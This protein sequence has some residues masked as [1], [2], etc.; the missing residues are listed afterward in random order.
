MNK[1]I[2]IALLLISAA[3]LIPIAGARPATLPGGGN[4]NPPGGQCS[5]LPVGM[6]LNI[7]YQAPWYCAI[8]AQIT[9][10]WESD[11]PLAEIALLIAFSIASV[12]F[13]VGAGIKSDRIRNFGIGELYEATASAII[14]L[15]FLFVSAVAFGL[16]PSIVVG[17]INPYATS[18]GLINKTINSAEAIYT[19]LFSIYVTDAQYTSITITLLI[20][21]APLKSIAS[22]ILTSI[23]QLYSAPLSIFVLEPASAIGGLI[24]D[25]ITAL[26]A[27]YYLL[28]F[29]ASV[30]IPAFLVPGTIFRAIFPTRAFGGMLIAL[31]MGFFIVMPSLFA[32]A[33]YFT[34]PNLLSSMQLT[35]SQL[36]RFGSGAGA[37]TNGLTA[38]SPLPTLLQNVNSEMSSFW[39]LILFYPSLIMAVTYAFVTQVATFIGGATYTGSRLR[40]FI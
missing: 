7:T 4:S 17:T 30:S 1:S 39:L 32:V 12:I 2:L 13:A 6:Q 28:I 23:P 5:S 25:G 19:S 40:S 14:I 38:T 31:A 3:A 21:G 34:A 20:G 27:E 9:S 35:A 16:V 15:I 26:Y 24:I 22:Q 11:L 37:E 18:L 8:N 29:F 36:T 10:V 33:Y